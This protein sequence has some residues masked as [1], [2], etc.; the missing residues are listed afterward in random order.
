MIGGSAQAPGMASPSSSAG[1]ARAT[2]ACLSCGRYEVA[3]AEDPSTGTILSFGGVSEDGSSWRSRPFDDGL[4]SVYSNGTWR[5][6]PTSVAPSARSDAG[7]VYDAKDGYF[8]LFGGNHPPGA[9]LLNDTWTFSN[10][11]WTELHPARSPPGLYY[12][13]LSFSMTYDAGDGVVLLVLTNCGC[14]D[15]TWAYTGGNWSAVSVNTEPSISYGALAY[16][17]AANTTVFYGGTVYGGNDTWTYNAGNWTDRTASAGTA[18]IVVGETLTDDPAAGGLVL[19]GGTSPTGGSSNATWTY[20]NGTWAEQNLSPSPPVGWASSTVYDPNASA[21]LLFG[22]HSP[23]YALLPSN[24]TW[25][26]AGGRWSVL[27]APHPGIRSDAGLVALGASGEALLFGGVRNGRPLNDT[28]RFANDSWTKLPGRG[29]PSARYGFGMAYDNATGSVVLFGGYDGTYLNDTW[30]FV[31]GRWSRLGTAVAPPAR[32]FGDLAYDPSD[33]DLLLFG[34]VASGYLG[35]TWSFN[36]TGWTDLTPGL[37]A[38][39]S[40]RYGAGMTYDPTAGALVLFGGYDGHYLSDTWE[41][42][43]GS[44]QVLVTYTTP[45][46]RAFGTFVYD[47]SL[48][49]D[50]LFGGYDGA[51]LNSTAELTSTGWRTLALGPTPA[52]RQRAAATYVGTGS[53]LLLFGGYGGGGS[54]LGDL[55]QLSA[56]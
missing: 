37:S 25:R 3:T 10:G 13:W 48:G 56:A 18:P 17:T 5:T 9:A 54:A 11:N 51:T 31:H 55:W 28:W 52:V 21:L 42:R 34:G 22:G 15:A 46:G 20:R 41:F 44:W 6:V 16:D 40:A 14:A 27:F 12:G 47:P 36:G 39:P 53:L 2:W 26:Y 33:G 30:T 8:L 35:D 49:G 4:T 45:T 50:I 43:N 29:A 7:L 38:A 1:A 19:F 32:A 24:E 23:R